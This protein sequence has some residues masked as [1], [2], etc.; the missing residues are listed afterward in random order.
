MKM[1]NIMGAI[2]MRWC[3]L[4]YNATDKC[5]KMYSQDAVDGGWSSV[6][7]CYMMFIF[8]SMIQVYYK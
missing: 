4:I 6:A 3:I 1:L 5:V 2:N 7:W 8:D